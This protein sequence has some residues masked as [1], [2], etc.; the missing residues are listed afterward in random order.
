MFPEKEG[1]GGIMV[2]LDPSHLQHGLGVSVID[3]GNVRAGRSLRSGLL[4]VFK[5]LLMAALAQQQLAEA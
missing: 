2:F 4:V 1:R 3:N 5:H